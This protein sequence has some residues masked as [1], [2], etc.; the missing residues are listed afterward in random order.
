MP[1][2]RDSSLETPTARRKLSVRKKPFY[3]RIAPGISLGY[4]RNEG[5][6]TWSVRVAQHGAEWIKRI[7]IADD[8]EVANPPLV[9]GYYAAI[10]EARKL[11]RRE[12]GDRHDASRPITVGDA[13]DQYEA[14]LGS[15]GGDIN[16]ARRVRLH[17]SPSLLAKPVGLLSAS[18]L[19][20]WCSGLVDKGLAPA[21]ANRWRNALRA[22]LTLAARKDRRIVNRHVWEEELEPLDDAKEARNVVLADDVV[23]KFVTAAYQHDHALGLLAHVMAETG[24]RPSQIVRLEVDDLDLSAPKLMMP[25]SGKGNPRQR[26]RKCARRP[27]CR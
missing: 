3:V 17:L 23:A 6:G 20:R 4:R 8:Y 25:K 26:A 16:N 1:K 5:A 13:L 18:G 21:S 9:L 14:N 7:A 19:T 15:R 2:V 22:A 11:A 10:D 27:R 24:A 12:P